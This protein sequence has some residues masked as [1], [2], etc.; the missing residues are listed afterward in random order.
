MMLESNVE[1]GCQPFVYGETRKEDLD[2]YISITDACIGWDETEEL[3][4]SAHKQL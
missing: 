2:P 4:L 3:I 1:E